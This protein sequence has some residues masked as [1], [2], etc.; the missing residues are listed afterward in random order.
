M[1]QVGTQKPSGNGERNLLIGVGITATI[2]ISAMTVLTVFALAQEWQRFWPNAGQPFA[3][4]LGGI[5]VLGGGALA[6]YNGRATRDHDKQIAKAEH[7]RETTKELNSRFTAAAAQLGN[8]TS[9]AI[10]QAGA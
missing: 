9:S 3:T 2:A 4:V 1:R 8:T 6:L 7:D 5:A 10:R